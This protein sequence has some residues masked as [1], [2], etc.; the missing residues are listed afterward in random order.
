MILTLI[1]PFGTYKAAP[2]PHLLLYWGGVV[3]W[4]A[5]TSI[6]LSSLIRVSM[7]SPS[8]LATS[9][10]TV[11]FTITFTPFLI[12]F[13]DA[14]LG[15]GS[16]VR[17]STVQLG[18]YV[19]IITSA[20]GGLIYQIEKT[21][22]PE[23]PEGPRLWRRLPTALQTD[24]IRL[25]SDGHYVSVHTVAGIHRLRLRFADATAEMDNVEGG[26]VHRSHWIARAHVRE[27][28]NRNNRPLLV[29]SDGAEVPVSRTYR[30]GAERMGLL[31]SEGKRAALQTSREA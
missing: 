10:S 25:S 5:F 24:I 16:G 31:P 29:M 22:K 28:I 18:L 30:G 8:V 6:F 15:D 2:H 13:T 27:V 11:L 20:I 12:W 19:L 17:L 4:A 1:G 26:C 14:V 3:F 7:R 21:L 9:L 23:E